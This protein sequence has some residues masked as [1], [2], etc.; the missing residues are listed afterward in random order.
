[1]VAFLF[2]IVAFGVSH[3]VAASYPDSKLSRGW[4]GLGF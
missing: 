2:M 3:L 4:T 1:M